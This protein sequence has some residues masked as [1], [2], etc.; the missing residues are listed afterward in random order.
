MKNIA[1]FP[2]SFD[3]F[4]NAHEYVVEQARQ[5]Y[6]K[7]IILVCVNPQKKCMFT[8]QERV[9]MIEQLIQYRVWGV[10]VDVDMWDGLLTDYAA[11]Y[12]NLYDNVHIVRGLRCDNGA[13]EFNL[14]TTYYEDFGVCNCHSFLQTIMIPVLDKD[15]M[16]TSSSRVREYIRRD[17]MNYVQAYCPSPIYQYIKEHQENLK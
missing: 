9:T 3:P 10:S 1:I 14:A 5:I 8:P 7:V 16:N 6:D 15:A 12:L 13:E 17:R 11:D 2:G 4:T